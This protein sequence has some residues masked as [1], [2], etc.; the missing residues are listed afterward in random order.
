[1]L[2]GLRADGTR[3]SYRDSLKPIRLFFCDRKSDPWAHDVRPAHVREFVTWRRGHRLTGKGEAKQAQVSERTVQKDYT[4]LHRIYAYAVEIEL[5]DANPVAAAARPQAEERDPVILTDGQFE[6]LLV[7][8]RTSRQP[9]LWL[10]ALALNDTGARSESEV[11]GLQWTDVHLEDGFLWIAIRGKDQRTKS[12][13]GRWIPM[14]SRFAQAMPEHFAAFRF[15]RYRGQPTPWVF[16]HATTRRHH[17]AGERIK[18][19]RGSLTNASKRAKL[20]EDFRPHDL[21]HRRVTTWLAEGRDVVKVKV[22]EALGH[23]DLRTTMGYTHL[24]R[25]HLTSLVSD[26][27]DADTLRRVLALLEER[28]ERTG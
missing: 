4:V 19:L 9:M 5:V 22:K 17:K 7:A 18:S 3:R 1:M 21:R 10:Y 15:A 24:A 8:C 26:T 11:L 6:D 12:G 27:P 14:T 16:H 13:K 25:E 2:P 20:P 23:A 28:D